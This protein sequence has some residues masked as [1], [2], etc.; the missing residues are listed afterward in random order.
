MCVCLK[1]MLFLDNIGCMFYFDKSLGSDYRAICNILL[2]AFCQNLAWISLSFTIL[3]NTGKEIV[4]D[5]IPYMQRKLDQLATPENIGGCI[6][7]PTGN[8]SNF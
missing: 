3:H 1:G 4:L 5:I 6:I 7:V 2:D 8:L